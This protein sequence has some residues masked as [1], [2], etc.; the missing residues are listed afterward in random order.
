M[1]FDK[2]IKR[3]LKI[4]NAD[5]LYSPVRGKVKE[6]SKVE[7]NVFSSGA[8]GKGIA[9]EPLDNCIYAPVS[10][11]VV[12]VFPTK[13]AICIEGKNG[14]ELLIHI[15]IDT[16]ELSGKYFDIKVKIGQTIEAGTIIAVVQFENIKKSGY[17]TDVIL[18]VA[19][20]DAYN[21]ERVF[22]EEFIDKSEALLNICKKEK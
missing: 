11:R 15:G 10:G 12:S 18:I 5:L 20:S 14:C 4:V 13:H 8:M 6:L 19:N 16:V 3:K 21:I 2:I 7:D 9:I 1:I 22:K 17:G